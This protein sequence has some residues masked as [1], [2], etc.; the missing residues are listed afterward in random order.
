[1]S[2]NTRLWDNITIKPADISGCYDLKHWSNWPELPKYQSSQV[3]IQMRENILVYYL[4]ECKPESAGVHFFRLVQYLWHVKSSPG[5]LTIFLLT[6]AHLVLFIKSHLVVAV[7]HLRCLFY[8]SQF[9]HMQLRVC[10][11]WEMWEFAAAA[12]FLQWWDRC[13]KIRPRRHRINKR[14]RGGGRNVNSTAAGGGNVVM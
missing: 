5:L 13:M 7:F 11:I 1:M 6:S 4:H 2:N 8:D 14:G 9:F 12:Q 10:E 3:L